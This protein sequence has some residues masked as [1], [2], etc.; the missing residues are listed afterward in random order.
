MILLRFQSAFRPGENIVVDESLLLY[1]GN[2][3]WKQFIKSKRARFGIKSFELCDSETGYL[4][5]LI[6]YCGKEKQIETKTP[7]VYGKSG[8]VVLELSENLF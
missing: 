8:D 3:S 7:S 1:K 6:I 4:Y 2:L 5:N